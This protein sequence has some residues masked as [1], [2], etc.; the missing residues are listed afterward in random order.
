MKLH[1]ILWPLL[2]RALNILRAQG[3][4]GWWYFGKYEGIHF[5]NGANPVEVRGGQIPSYN[6]GATVSDDC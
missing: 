4:A 1:L 6:Y 5:P 3:E 2:I